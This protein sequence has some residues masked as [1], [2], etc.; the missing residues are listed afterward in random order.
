MKKTR[1]WINRSEY[2]LRLNRLIQ[3]NCDKVVARH[4]PVNSGRLNSPRFLQVRYRYT[5]TYKVIAKSSRIHPLSVRVWAKCRGSQSIL[6]IRSKSK[7]SLS[8]G[9]VLGFQLLLRESYRGRPMWGSCPL[10]SL[11]GAAPT[12]HCLGV[13]TIHAV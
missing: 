3:G 11:L 12:Q 13:G 8:T 9:T 6:A 2:H 10:P 7:Y 5:D 4:N 1:L